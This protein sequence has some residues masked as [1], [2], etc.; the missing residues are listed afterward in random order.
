MNTEA[1]KAFRAARDYLLAHRTDY[2]T[3]RA[4]FRWPE[5]AEFNWALDHFDQVAADPG[6]AGRTALWIVE[7]DGA[8]ARFSYARAR[9][10]LQ[11]GGQLAA[12][13]GACAAATG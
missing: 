1:T 10:P 5:L 6:T 3:A 7:Q 8:E 9:G 13:A 11:P 12:R 4:E 2:D